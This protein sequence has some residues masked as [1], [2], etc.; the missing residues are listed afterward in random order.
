MTDISHAELDRDTIER[1]YSRW[2]PVYDLVFGAVFERGRQAAVAAAER[3]G[4]RILEVGVGT[5]ISLPDY[6]HANRLCGVDISESMLRKAQAQGAFDWKKF[7]GQS[8]DVLLEHD[9][10]LHRGERRAAGEQLEQQ[11]A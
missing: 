5:G 7:S 10:R 9:H 6:S 2:A 4:G 3:I 8:I 1:A 11:A